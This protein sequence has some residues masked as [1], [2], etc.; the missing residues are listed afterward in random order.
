MEDRDRANIVDLVFS[1]SSS[2]FETMDDS[3]SH[4][5]T[6]ATFSP[7]IG[8]GG[9]FLGAACGSPYIVFILTSGM[10]RSSN[11]YIYIYIYI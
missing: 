10:L 1:S 4:L 8:M 7:I 3:V 6:N 11:I 5:N 2:Q 9:Q